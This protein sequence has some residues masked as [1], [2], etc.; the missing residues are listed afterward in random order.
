MPYEVD[1]EYCAC[2]GNEQIYLSYCKQ[3]HAQEKKKKKKRDIEERVALF[4][5]QCP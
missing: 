4:D 1:V 5:L 2:A 3:T